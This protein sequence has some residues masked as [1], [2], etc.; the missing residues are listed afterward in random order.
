LEGGRIELGTTQRQ[1]GLDLGLFNRRA[2]IADGFA[3]RLRPAKVLQSACGS[4][5]G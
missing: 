4:T 5:F 3:H 1:V 2:R